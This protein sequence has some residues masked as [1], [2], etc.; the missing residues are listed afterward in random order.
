MLRQRERRKPRPQRS[1]LFA[2]HGPN[3]EELD[4]S[5]ISISKRAGPPLV[6]THP[7]DEDVLVLQSMKLGSVMVALDTACGYGNYTDDMEGEYDYDALT[8][9]YLTV[10]EVT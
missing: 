7:D 5:L 3:P 1:V 6:L 4:S 8:H 10:E 2:R 9:Q